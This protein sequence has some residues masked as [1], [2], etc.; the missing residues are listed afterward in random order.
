M[1]SSRNETRWWCAIF[2]MSLSISSIAQASSIELGSSTSLSS[3]YSTTIS[4][5][6]NDFGHRL[7]EL[8]GDKNRQFLKNL[9]VESPK[10]QESF[11]IDNEFKP[12][13]GSSD[14]GGNAVGD[15]FF[16]FYENEGSQEVSAI[17]LVRLEPMVGLKLEQL[18]RA[19]PAVDSLSSGGLGDIL[20][21]SLSS[22]KLYLETKSISSESCVNQSMVATRNQQIV[23][24][25][26][27]LDIRF[28]AK[29]MS[30]EDVK[31]KDIAGLI[32]HEMFLSWAR[33]RKLLDSKDVLEQKVRTINRAVFQIQGNGM[34]VIDLLENYFRVKAYTVDEFAK[35]KK[36][37][38]IVSALVLSGPE[39]STSGANLNFTSRQTKGLA[40]QQYLIRQAIIEG[41][42]T[43]TCLFLIDT[44][45]RMKKSAELTLAGTKQEQKAFDEYR[46]ILTPEHCQ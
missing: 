38:A 9:T 34:S 24:C 41:I 29:W 13:G 26:S 40:K 4:P 3:E 32:L 33:D 17:E 25:Q 44:L 23:G 15:S 12:S 31:S 42:D 36:R 10:L 19:I 46:M 20:L 1:K 27:D 28:D 30:R 14:G 16:D 6:L 5:K 21:K 35:F 22:K 37:A 8:V 7:I 43:A 11:K 45:Y 39:P 18:N 2:A